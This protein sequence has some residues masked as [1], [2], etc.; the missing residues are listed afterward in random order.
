ML[1]NFFL[2]SAVQNFYLVQR[3]RRPPNLRLIFYLSFHRLGFSF[4]LIRSLF[5][6]IFDPERRG[7]RP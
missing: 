6:V 1:S 5:S 4:I 2:P 3:Q 7:R